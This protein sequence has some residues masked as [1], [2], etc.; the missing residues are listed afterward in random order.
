MS[1]SKELEKVDLKS[2][3]KSDS[4]YELYCKEYNRDADISK[5]R[6]KMIVTI[7]KSKG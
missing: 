7:V 4:L 6:Y 3:L 5:G 2:A 1:F